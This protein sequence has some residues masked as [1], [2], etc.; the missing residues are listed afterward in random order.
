[1]GRLVSRNLEDELMIKIKKLF[2]RIFDSVIKENPSYSFGFEQFV[3]SF[4]ENDHYM[5]QV[6]EFLIMEMAQR[7]RTANP[8]A[9]H[10]VHGRPYTVQHFSATENVMDNTSSSTSDNSA[11]AGTGTGTSTGTGTGTSQSTVENCPADTE[12]R[13]VHFSPKPAFAFEYNECFVQFNCFHGDFSCPEQRSSAESC[14]TG[15]RFIQ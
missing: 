14:V 8:N 5:K 10:S 3:D 13:L 4:D 7:Y 11:S 9:Q 15:N 12:Q 6:F 2:D 1:M